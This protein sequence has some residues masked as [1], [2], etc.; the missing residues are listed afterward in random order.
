MNKEK[1]LIGSRV[2][3]IAKQKGVPLY[4]LEEKVHIAKGS[5]SKW[6]EI[7]PSFDKVMRVAKELNVTS[8][9]LIS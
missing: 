6:D 8:D 9:D 2:K 1:Y 3:E 5:I 7:N 4:V